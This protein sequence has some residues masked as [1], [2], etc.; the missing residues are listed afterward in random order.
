MKRF[1]IRTNEEVEAL[2][3]DQR[4]K[5]A[6]I[7]QEPATVEFGRTFSVLRL[8]KSRPQTEQ[9]GRPRALKVRT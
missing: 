3:A 5:D 4:R 8:D 7:L 1:G 6:A 9:G 2:C